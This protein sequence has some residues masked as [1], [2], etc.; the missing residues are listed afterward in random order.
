M[1]SK[2]VFNYGTV[3][4][5]KTCN[6]LNVCF[7]Y[8][9]VGWNVCVIKPAIDTRSEMIETR[10][11][12]PPRKADIV[13]NE[14]DS[15]YDY[16]SIINS[17]DVVLVDECQFLTMTQVEELRSIST[18]RNINILCFGLRT[19]FNT[20]LFPASKRLF[21][22]ADEINEVRTVC[23]VCGKRAGFNL[24]L[25]PANAEGNILPS[26]DS[27]SQRCYLHYINRE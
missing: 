19:D 7:N 25:D 20:N 11:H 27:F 8:E 2:L 4:S 6:L 1:C 18:D 23:S 15:I 21:E 22:L 17:A 13:L 24:K 5:G 10:A 26:W 12:V 14:S 16:E 9:K 3:C